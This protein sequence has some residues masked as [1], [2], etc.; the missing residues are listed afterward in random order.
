MRYI[1]AT[2]QRRAAAAQL[3]E[4]NE[5]IRETFSSTYVEVELVDNPGVLIRVLLDSGAA[6]SVFSKTST[7]ARVVQ[8]QAHTQEVTSRR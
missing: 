5:K 6:L 3:T 2:R 1:A 8:S 7:E 4:Q